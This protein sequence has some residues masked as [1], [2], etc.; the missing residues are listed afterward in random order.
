MT[1][2]IRV[3]S[4]PRRIGLQLVGVELSTQAD[5]EDAGNDSV[6]AILRVRVRHQFHAARY[7]DSDHVGTRLRRLTD[8]D[9]E[10]GQRWKRRERLPVDILGQDCSEN[11]LAW[12]MGSNCSFV[13]SVVIAVCFCGI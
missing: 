10:A 2:A 9:G 12:L 3:E 11:G 8:K 4:E 7:F 6:D 5:V 1:F 13:V